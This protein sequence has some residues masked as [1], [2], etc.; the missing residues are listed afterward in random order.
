MASDTRRNTIIPRVPL[1]GEFAL[2]TKKV[3][4]DRVAITV[5]TVAQN[6][7]PTVT[8]DGRYVM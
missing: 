5:V 4:L 1:F 2:Q 6:H 7:R 8:H 3:R